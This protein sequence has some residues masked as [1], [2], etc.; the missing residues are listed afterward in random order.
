MVYSLAAIIAY[1]ILLTVFSKLITDEGQQ[2]PT[3]FV[4][5]GSP[6]L[7]TRFP[8]GEYRFIRFVGIKSNSTYAICRR[9]AVD[10]SLRRIYGKSMTN[11][12]SGVWL[13][14]ALLRR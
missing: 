14:T 3:R 12:I 2:G 6:S 5:M 10:S 1:Y 11:R 7:R 8:P 13:I 9:F 4:T